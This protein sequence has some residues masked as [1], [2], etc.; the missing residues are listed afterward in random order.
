[1]FGLIFSIWSVKG[2][3]IEGREE[4]MAFGFVIMVT[5]SIVLLINNL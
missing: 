2:K 3:N 4:G 5:A 1:M